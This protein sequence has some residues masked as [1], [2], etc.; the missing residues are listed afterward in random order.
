MLKKQLLKLSLVLLASIT[1]SAL[2]AQTSEPQVYKEWQMLEE[3]KTMI[4]VS[5]R[6]LKCS[7]TN[8][9]HLMV[10][11]ENVMDQNA[12]FSLEVTEE[13]SGQKLVKDFDFAATKATMYKA[14]CSN[15]TL[16]GAL[17]FDLPSNYDPTKLSVKLTFKP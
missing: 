15:N 17:K 14:D 9:I 5:Y 11:N 2:S 7:E 1:F 8:Q 16:L 10:F 4:D 3:S 13:V 6:V 12:R